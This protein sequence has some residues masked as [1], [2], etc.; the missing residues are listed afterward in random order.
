[1][2]SVPA[3]IYRLLAYPV[4]DIQGNQKIQR[5]HHIIPKVLESLVSLLLPFG[6]LFYLFYIIASRVLDI[7]SKRNR[8]KYG[9]FIFRKS[10]KFLFYS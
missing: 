4:L 10:P 7:L 5:T 9:P 2:F 3:D 1:M 6:V 8:G